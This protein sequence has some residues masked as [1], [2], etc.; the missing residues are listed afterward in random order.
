[1][2]DSSGCYV[3]GSTLN[4]STGYACQNGSCVRSCSDEC[5]S[6]SKQC[7]GTGG[8]QTCVKGSSG[9]YVWGSTTD[10]NNG[11]A[12]QNGS[13]V[14]SCSDEC[15]SGAKECSGDAGYRICGNYDSDKC[16][17]WGTVKNCTNSYVCQDGVCV[18]SCSDE[19]SLGQKQCSGDSAYQ[20]CAKNS[21]GCSVW[22]VSKDC[23]FGYGCQNGSCVN[24]CSDECSPGEKECSG[25]SGYRTCGKYDLDSCYEWSAVKNCSTGYACQ[26]GGCVKGCSDQCTLGDHQCSGTSGRTCGNYGSNS[27]AGWS[28]YDKCDG[29]CYFCGDGKCNSDCGETKTSCSKDCGTDKPTVDLAGPGSVSCQGSA[30]LTWTSTNAQTCAASGGWSGAKETS[31]SETIDNITANKTFTLKCTGLGGSTSDNIAISVKTVNPNADAGD[32]LKIDESE[33]IQLDGSNSTSGSDDNDLTYTWTCNG[34]TLDNADTARP[35]FFA[36]E[37]SRDTVY[38]CTLKVTNNCGKIDSDTVNIAVK[39]IVTGQFS[40]NLSVSPDN[41]CAPL[42][43]VDLTAKVSEIQGDQDS[44]YTYYFSCEGDGNWDKTITTAATTY[45]ARDLCDYQTANDYRAKVKVEGSESGKEATDSVMIGANDCGQEFTVRLKTEPTGGCKPLNNVDL[46]ATI[47]NYDSA[48]NNSDEFTYRFDCDNDGNWDKTITTSNDTYTA[49]DL[50]DYKTAATHTAK[51]T[52]EINGNEASDTAD[53]KVKSCASTEFNVD[54]TARPDNGCAPLSNVDL[55]AH[56][57]GYDNQSDDEYTYYFDCEDDGTWD[58]TIT[59]TATTYTARGLCDY[60]SADNYTARVKVENSGRSDEDSLVINTDDC[61]GVNGRI[62]VDK[63]VSNLSRGAGYFD[64]VNALPG[65]FVNFKI[66]IEAVSDN[67]QELRLTDILPRGISN[68]RDIRIDGRTVNNDLANGLALDDLNNGDTVTVS[69]TATVA[70]A[71]EFNYGQTT[72]TNTATARGKGT[73]DSD[74]AD[75]VVQRAEIEGITTVS[76]GFTDNPFVD[77][78]VIPLS[79][80][81]LLIWTLKAKILAIEAWLDLRRIAFTK[82]QSQKKLGAKIAQLKVKRITDRFID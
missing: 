17:E 25:D 8:Y 9:C 33:D 63:T 3:W 26:D 52:V 23:S 38:T 64:S 42:N 69:F 53:V 22:G 41:G 11:Y 74:T 75:V 73:S 60:D 12:C 80:S 13:C 70:K 18:R 35:T 66:V 72:V 5:T 61:A 78:F 29:Q 47:A 46:I 21:Q 36:A 59:T 56:L 19:C 32:D 16:L 6:G 27:C 1:M 49:K 7:S 4:C 34:G 28:G 14:S 48:G 40:V 37:I 2:K 65:D 24:S 76:T 71:S 45:T 57:T 44:E 79:L 62:K 55:T 77:S 10:C 50:C 43:N 81:L 68:P 67:V 31:G 39:N 58:K 15:I 30:T 54:L 82:F 20:I 51:V